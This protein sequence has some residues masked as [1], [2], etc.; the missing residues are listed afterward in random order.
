MSD[1]TNGIQTRRPI[2]LTDVLDSGS[3]SSN[4]RDLP[5]SWLGKHGDGTDASDTYS[6]DRQ[7]WFADYQ[8]AS[9]RAMLP[10]TGRTE[11]NATA[12]PERCWVSGQYFDD[13]ESA[14]DSRIKSFLSYSEDWDGDG[15]REISPPTVYAALN[16]LDEFRWRFFGKEPCGAAPSPD[17]EIVVYWHG[18]EG[19]AEVNFDSEGNISMCWRA[20]KDEMNLIEPDE[21]IGAELGKSAIW[22]TLSEFLTSGQSS[23]E[24]RHRR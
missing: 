6:R 17:G 15:A 24:T 14:L 19:Y 3:N 1:S 8:Q 22:S 13:H 20:G 16:F 23:R 5:G 10:W 12:G 7:F 11:P 9:N 21:E 18:P 4:D 2:T